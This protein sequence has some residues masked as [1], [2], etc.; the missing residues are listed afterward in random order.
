MTRRA[1]TIG[2]LLLPAVIHMAA[3]FAAGAPEV[4]E[5]Q[6][7]Q[8]CASAGEM[9]VPAGRHKPFFKSAGNREV[10]VAPM[11]L[12]VAPVSNAQYLEFVRTHPEWRRSRIDRIYAEPNYLAQW[13]DDLTPPA[14]S[15]SEPV[16]FV[17]WFAAS[18]FCEAHGSRLPRVR[19]WE[20]FAG[21]RTSA[22]NS[23]AQ[24][25]GA[26][27]APGPPFAFAMGHRAADLARSPLV[28]ARI[29]EWTEDF[30]SSVL[31]G[32]LG[33]AQDGGD[34][35]LFCGDG[36]RAT[37]ATDYAA[38]LRYSFRSSL[39]GDFTLR[40]LGFRCTRDAP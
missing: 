36:Y 9:F 10:P 18:E 6:A 8:V 2:G 5:S 35:T 24:A 33:R 26:T 4:R 14:E 32:G 1:V 21:A 27:G 38:F 11:C 25:D 15:L 7:R 12:D 16:V 28:L 20:R 23:A 34:S 31:A 22:P 3:A 30:N 19:E 39:R 29:W 37:D 13:K 40:N 17:S